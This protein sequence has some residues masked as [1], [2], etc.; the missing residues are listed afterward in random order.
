MKNHKIHIN[1][2][3]TNSGGSRGSYVAPL[4]MG[5]REFKDIDMQPYTIPVSKYNDS[6]LEYDSYDGQMSLPKKQVNKIEKKAKK[7]SDYIKN[8]PYLTFSDEDGN[9]I[10]QYPKGYNKKSIVPIK[11]AD[12]STS[13]GEYSGPIELGMKKWDSNSLEP[14]TEFVNTE[15]N[16]KKVKS[17]T[18]NNVNR[19]VGVWEKNKDGSYN[20]ET[21]KVHTIKENNPKKKIV[22][23]SEKDLIRII[24]EIINEQLK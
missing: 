6:M 3:T 10:N 13:A 14:F 4:Q 2:A 22:R 9:V 8:H 18:K 12:T 7:T 11:E 5:V 15:I 21:H 24:K 19:V 16:R 17:S 20:V 1:E 23:L